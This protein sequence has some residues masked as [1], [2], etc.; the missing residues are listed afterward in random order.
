MK[1]ALLAF[2]NIERDISGIIKNGRCGKWIIIKK[3]TEWQQE[4]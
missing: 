3:G 2:G 1:V 4:L